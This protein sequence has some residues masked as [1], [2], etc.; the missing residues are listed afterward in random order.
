MQARDII[1]RLALQPQPEGGYRETEIWHFY[2]CAQPG[3]IL[4]AGGP[5]FEFADFR[6]VASLPDHQPPFAHALRGLEGLL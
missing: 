2:G 3:G 6:L 4:P 1:R 5:G